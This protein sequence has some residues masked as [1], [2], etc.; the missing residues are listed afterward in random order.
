MEHKQPTFIQQNTLFGILIGC[1]CVAASYVFFKQTGNI[2]ANPSLDRIITFLFV[3]GLFMQIRRYRESEELKGYISYGRALLTGMYLSAVA[4]F[5][6]GSYALII[7]SKHPDT[8]E[9]YLMYAES[10]FRQL[11][12]ESPWADNMIQMLQA[13]TT[14]VSMGITEFFS[15]ALMGL[16]YTLVIAFILK[17]RKPE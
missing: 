9:N 8:L 12:P 11:Y 3:I 13:F 5:F 6:Y 2:Y 7:Y 4:G 16:I 17:K 14:P 10:L 1:C 15:K